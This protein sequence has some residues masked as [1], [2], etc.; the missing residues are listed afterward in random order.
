MKNIFNLSI[1]K[2]RNEKLFLTP[3][4]IFKAKNFKEERKKY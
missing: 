2:F 3:Q 1:R 4:N